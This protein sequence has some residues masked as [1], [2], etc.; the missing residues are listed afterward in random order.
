M[1]KIIKIAALILALLC[2]GTCFA[3][4]GSDSSIGGGLIPEA[5][6]S[7]TIGVGARI[8]IV[9][10][11]GEDIDSSNYND[12]VIDK[13]TNSTEEFLAAFKKL[14]P[15]DKRT[16]RGN[17]FREASIEEKNCLKINAEFINGTGYNLKISITLPEKIKKV[18]YTY[19]TSLGWEYSGDVIENYGTLSSDRKTVTFY[20]ESL[21]INTVD[22][23]PY[24]GTLRIY[25]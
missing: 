8:Y 2:I 19:R 14:K 13:T 15:D 25:F 1:K 20:G 21:M 22:D 10:E 16:E 24:L 9:G 4:C 6:K 5:D 23:K 3:S 18:T 17:I 12:F 7:E 11:V